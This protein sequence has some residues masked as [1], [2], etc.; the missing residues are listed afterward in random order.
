MSNFSIRFNQEFL[1]YKDK[2]IIAEDIMFLV[3]TYEYYMNEKIHKLKTENKKLREALILLR[4][5]LK[6]DS[7][8]SEIIKEALKRS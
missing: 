1:R 3:S 7:G 4:K 6:W 8:N 5:N 2:E